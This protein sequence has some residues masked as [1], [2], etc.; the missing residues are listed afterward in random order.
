M[1]I[2]KSVDLLV[3]VNELYNY[4]IIGIYMTKYYYLNS[5]D[6]TVE[7]LQISRPDSHNFNFQAQGQNKGQ[8]Q[9][10]K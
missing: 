1:S 5:P 9:S 2:S 10:Q 6:L 7:F 4:Y 3:K 8:N